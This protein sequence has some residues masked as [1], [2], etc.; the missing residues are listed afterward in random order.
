MGGRAGR[1]GAIEVQNGWE[2]EIDIGKR[3]MVITL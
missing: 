3:R 1:Q 2:Y